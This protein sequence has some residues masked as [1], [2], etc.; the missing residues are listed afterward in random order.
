[1]NPTFQDKGF[2]FIPTQTKVTV[3]TLLL[4]PY[5]LHGLNLLTEILKIAGFPHTSWK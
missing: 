4:R 3:R 5:I 1:M 2:H